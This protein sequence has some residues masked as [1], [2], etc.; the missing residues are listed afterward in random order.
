[1]FI[2]TERCLKD[3]QSLLT[4]SELLAMAFQEIK[5]FSLYVSV[6]FFFNQLSFK[7]RKTDFKTLV[8][9]HTKII[10]KRTF[11]IRYLC[12]HMCSVLPDL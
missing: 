10:F 11:D 7:T 2:Y 12:I 4:L 6:G 1:M 8:F 3:H 5:I 9:K